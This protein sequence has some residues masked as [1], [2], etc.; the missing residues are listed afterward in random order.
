[1]AF[2]LSLKDFYTDMKIIKIKKV[3][4]CLESSNVHDIFLNM[5]VSKIFLDSIAQNG[6]LII[7]DEMEK[8]FFKLIVKG[9]Y[10]LKGSIG[11]KVIRIVL[12]PASDNRWQEE[13]KEM[14]QL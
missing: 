9:K 10:T 3:D 14:I 12:P 4:G 8:P 13:I 2:L 1:M 7:Y 5:Q 11:N 6:K